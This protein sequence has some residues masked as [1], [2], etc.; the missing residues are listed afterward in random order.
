MK[1]LLSM[2]LLVFLIGC[3]EKEPKV[4]D[5]MVRASS[6]AKFWEDEVLKWVKKDST[7]IF[8]DTVEENRL[9]GFMQHYITNISLHYECAIPLYMKFKHDLSRK[10]ESKDRLVDVRGNPDS[11]FEYEAILF[12]KDKSLL[13]NRIYFVYPKGNSVI[14]WSRRMD[15]IHAK[16][17][18][19]PSLQLPYN[20]DSGIYH[21]TK[22]MLSHM[23]LGNHDYSLK[24][25]VKKV[26]DK[27]AFLYWECGIWKGLP[28][29]MHILSADR[30]KE[31]VAQGDNMV[32]QMKVVFHFN[33]TTIFSVY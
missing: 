7:K 17:E 25:F 27:K 32:L 13:S 30:F 14:V 12:G 6:T 21:I 1:K 33:N 15:C 18:F 29:G 24:E 28:E 8:R 11:A 10:R 20:P 9:L 23:F 16:Y 4:E 5:C 26:M 19:L 2:M 22:K 31:W 3:L